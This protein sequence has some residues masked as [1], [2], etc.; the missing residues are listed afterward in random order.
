[1][2]GFRS[3]AAHQILF[4]D[5]KKEE[6]MGGACGMHGGETARAHVVLVWR[7]HL[8]ERHHLQDTV[9]DRR[10]AIKLISRN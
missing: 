7:G 1:M 9:V 5:R 8:K 4:G 10:T 3:C 6:E 2:T